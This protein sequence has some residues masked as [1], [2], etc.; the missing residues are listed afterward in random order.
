LSP[1]AEAQAQ[2]DDNR[3]VQAVGVSYSSASTPTSAAYFSVVEGLS[4]SCLSGVIY[5]DLTVDFGRGA[6]AQLLSAKSTGQMLTRI[7]YSQDS[8]TNLCWLSMAQ[9][10]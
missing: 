10:G 7:V 9:I 5:V 6:L 3:T 8:S 1:I 4:L 2:E